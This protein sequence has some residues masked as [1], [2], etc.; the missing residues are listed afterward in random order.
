MAALTPEEIHSAFLRRVDP[1]GF[2]IVRA[3]DFANAS[4]DAG[5]TAAERPRRGR[6][7]GAAP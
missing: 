3:G 5:G 4:A 2:S 6:P 7:E 1:D